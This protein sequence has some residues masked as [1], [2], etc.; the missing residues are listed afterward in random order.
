MSDPT[1]IKVQQDLN[2]AVLPVIFMELQIFYY[3][4]WLTNEEYMQELT[5][6][7]RTVFESDKKM[8]IK[9][10]ERLPYLLETK[11]LKTLSLGSISF[12]SDSSVASVDLCCIPSVIARG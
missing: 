4:I 7:L 9:N 11:L 2:S 6:E 12:G 1:S 3:S 5:S 10:A 8:T